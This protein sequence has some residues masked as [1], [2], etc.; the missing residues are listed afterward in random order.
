MSPGL[1]D[2]SYTF[3]SSRSNPRGHVDDISEGLREVR[4][5]SLNK[6]MGNLFVLR[7]VS[8]LV[9]GLNDCSP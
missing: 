1:S 2:V 4:T 5:V 9:A 6:S 8:L 7:V 3:V